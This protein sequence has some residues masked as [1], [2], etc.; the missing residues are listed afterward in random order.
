MYS[1]FKDTG[2]E[3]LGY[4]FSPLMVFS[5]IMDKFAVAEHYMDPV[6]SSDVT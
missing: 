1:T 2:A 5:N 6:K 3:T 4:I